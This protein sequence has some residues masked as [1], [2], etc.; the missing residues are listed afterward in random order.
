MRNTCQD[1]IYKLAV[2]NK[3]VIF[4]GSDLGAGV[5]ENLKKNF[6]INSLWRVYLSNT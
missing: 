5:Q 1:E 3:K 4:V 6:Q 2:K